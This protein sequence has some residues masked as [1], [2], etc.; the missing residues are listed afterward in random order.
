MST[1]IIPYLFFAGRCEEAL[2]FYVK[3]LDAKVERV[4][5]Y[6]ESPEPI[7]P[8]MLQP[9]F[10]KKVMHAAF[11]VSGVEIFASDGRDDRS[12]FDGFQLAISVDTE[13]EARKAFNGLADGGEI[14][15]PLTETFYS[16]CFGMLTDKFKVGWML[17]VPKPM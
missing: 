10:E 3:A 13:A 15:M 2:E 14:V 16:P 1:R 8:G 11:T 17:I 5:H 7:P 6:N 9:G 4:M 12:N